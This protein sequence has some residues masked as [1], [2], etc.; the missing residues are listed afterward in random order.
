MSFRDNAAYAL[1]LDRVRAQTPAELA[2]VSRRDLVLTHIWEHPDLYRGVPIHLLGT[3]MRVLR[4]ESKLTKTGWLYEAWIITPETSRVPYACVFEDAPQGLPI[5][6][7]LAERVVFNGYFL[8]IL[9]YAAG[10]VDRGAPLLVGRVG[11]EPHEAASPAQPA[12]MSPT[13][14]WTLIALAAMFVISLARWIVQLRRA[15]ARPDRSERTRTAR[16][17]ELDPVALDEWVQAV[18]HEDDASS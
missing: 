7:N 4:Y 2:A 18:A 15:V 12:G 5:G 16:T 6:P 11:W 13:L 1:L 9:K 3:A 17:D 14:R 10:D 8:K